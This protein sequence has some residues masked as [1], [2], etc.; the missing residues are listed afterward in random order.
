[1]VTEILLST[2][3]LPAYGTQPAQRGTLQLPSEPNRAVPTPDG[4]VIEHSTGLDVRVGEFPTASRLLGIFAIALSAVVFVVLAGTQ[5]GG[6]L[7]VL[8][9]PIVGCVAGV[10]IL[11]NLRRERLV[12]DK[13]AAV[14]RVATDYFLPCRASDV[15]LIPFAGFGAMLCMVHRRERTEAALFVMLALQHAAADEPLFLVQRAVNGSEGTLQ[16]AWA[17][18]FASLCA[19]PPGLLPATGADPMRRRDTAVH[20][21]DGVATGTVVGTAAQAPA[22]LVLGVPVQTQPVYGQPQH[23]RA[24]TPPL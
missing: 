6:R 2:Y 19:G 5:R 24:H 9:I 15:E 18:Y 8:A 23:H 20:I 11:Y 17:S 12:F 21:E 4:L 7:A 16:L 22:A 10:T 13:G 14:L 3:T 1:M